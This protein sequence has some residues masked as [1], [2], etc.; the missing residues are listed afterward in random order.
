MWLLDGTKGH[1]C[2]SLFVFW[3]Q[4]KSSLP[5]FFILFLFSLRVLI[6][7]QSP[8]LPIL[9]FTPSLL[10]KW[11]TNLPSGCHCLGNLGW[12]LCQKKKLFWFLEAFIYW[13][14]FPSCSAIAAVMLTDGGFTCQTSL[15]MV[16]RRFR[17]FFQDTFKHLCGAKTLQKKLH[18]QAVTRRER[19]S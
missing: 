5:K 2:F 7:S 13:F 12:T 19:L 6:S 11:E 4:P 16:P 15:H 18:F 14:I 8:P 10:I 9:M 3:Q 1:C 17:K